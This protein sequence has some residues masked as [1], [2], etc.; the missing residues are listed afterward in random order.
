[1]ALLLFGSLKWALAADKSIAREHLGNILEQLTSSRP[2]LKL[3]VAFRKSFSMA[4]VSA[5]TLA[6]SGLFNL[7][8]S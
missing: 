6:C 7:S 2:F 1:M 8:C 3:F 5:S 4:L